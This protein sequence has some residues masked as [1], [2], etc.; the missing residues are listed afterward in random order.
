MA[1]SQLL[2]G[3]DKGPNNPLAKLSSQMNGDRGAQRVRRRR[4]LARQLR[5]MPPELE[6]IHS[7]PLFVV[8]FDRTPTADH[9]QD[10]HARC[11]D[12]SSC[13]FGVVEMSSFGDRLLVHPSLHPSPLDHPVILLQ[14]P[15]PTLV[16]F[17]AAETPEPVLS[18]RV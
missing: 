2:S 17:V 3:G 12:P 18:R 16:V 13:V 15:A 6:L 9:K 5:H 8:A 11:V 7:F 4:P 1:M 10:H 14:D